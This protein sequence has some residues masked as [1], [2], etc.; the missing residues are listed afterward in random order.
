MFWRNALLAALLA[1]AG[2]GSLPRAFDG[3]VGASVH[4]VAP[5]PA[6][7]AIPTSKT[8]LLDPTRAAQLATALTIGLRGLEVPAFAQPAA[9]GDWV[10]EITAQSASGLVAP[11]Y[12]IH[13]PSGA[14]R[15]RIAGATMAE[16]DFPITINEQQDLLMVIGT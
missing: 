13:D 14:E 7:L 1:L 4:L 10:V 3:P 12:V 2:C 16:A 15:G 8:A 9:P 11:A 5:P 6:R